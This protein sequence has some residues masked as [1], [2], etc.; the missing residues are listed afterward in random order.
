MNDKDF[1]SKT[2]RDEA[3]L[4]RPGPELSEF[5]SDIK[6]TLMQDSQIVTT[7]VA[8]GGGVMHHVLERKETML[9]FRDWLPRACNPRV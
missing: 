8:I 9:P 6:N 5:R 7:P 1:K 2:T 4:T 3:D